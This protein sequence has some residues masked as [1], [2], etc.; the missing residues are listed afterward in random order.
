MKR[1]VTSYESPDLDG[2]S[3]MYAYSEYLN[4]IGIQSDY[5]VAKQPKQEVKIV[6]DLFH[7]LL[8][9]ATKI[10]D[11]QEVVVLDTNNLAE[12]PFVNPENIVEIIDHHSKNESNKK[13]TKA[14]IQIERLGAVATLIAEKFKENHTPISRNAAILLYY[15]IISNSINLKANVTDQKDI[16]MVNWLQEQCSEISAEKIKEI[17]TL[18]SKIEDDKLREEMEAELAFDYND[19]SITIAQLEVANVEE[20]LKEK[21]EKIVGILKQIKKEKARDYILINCI[22]ILNGFNIILTIDDQTEELLNKL[23]GYKF[24]NRRCKFNKIM[25][26]KDL[27]KVIR[28]NSK[29]E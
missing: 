23:F 7:I 12:V 22:D 24:K 3:S 6:C 19:K 8:E 1:I 27:S 28:E 20:F 21:E 17:F 10:E 18:K 29:K 2:V 14:R 26:R 11:N 15:G 4:K 9:G 16:Q 5:Y 13:C 25:Q